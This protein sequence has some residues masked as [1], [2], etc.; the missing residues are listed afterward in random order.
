MRD[1]SGNQAPE[2]ADEAMRDALPA[3]EHGRLAERER[4]A[5]EAHLAGCG[6]CTAELALLRD[7]RGAVGGDAPPLDLDRLALAVVAATVRPAA[8]APTNVIPLAPRIARAERVSAARRWY[9]GGGLRAAAA[10]LL[11]ALGAGAVTV[12]RRDEP[13]TRSSAANPPA[14]V[15]ASAS[16]TTDSAARPET[17]PSPAGSEAPRVERP[18]AT[19]R[20]HALGEGFDD[21]TDEELRAVLR[22][23][24]SDDASLPALEPAEHAS[25]YRGGGA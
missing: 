3:L 11:V 20:S 7:V 14:A 1:H 9:A 25:E 6:A 5:V 13:T 4:R 16:P 17:T 15:L 22:A 2:C 8:S 10:A 23:I 18:A 12:A 21:L 19:G 24:E